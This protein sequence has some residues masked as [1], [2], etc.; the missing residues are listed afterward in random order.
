MSADYAGPG[1]V[2]TIPA[3]GLIWKTGRQGLLFTDALVSAV[4]PPAAAS[5]APTGVAQ[6]GRRA[7]LRAVPAL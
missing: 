6:R 3:S 1:I 7:G 4:S 2:G 5:S